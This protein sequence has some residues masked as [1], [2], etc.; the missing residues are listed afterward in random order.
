MRDDKKVWI[1]YSRVKEIQGVDRDSFE[2][3]TVTDSVGRAIYSYDNNFVYYFGRI[4]F[5]ADPET[6]EIYDIPE[7]LES[8]QIYAYDKNHVYKQ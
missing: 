1:N 2:L 8:F 3:L 4:I 7:D 6:F 5:E